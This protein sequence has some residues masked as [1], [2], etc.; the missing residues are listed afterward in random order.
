MITL[1][2]GFDFAVPICRVVF[3]LSS[4]SWTW[5][6]LRARN[7]ENF[8]LEI[9]QMPESR[10]NLHT[11]RLMSLFLGTVVESV[12]LFHVSERTYSSFCLALELAAWELTSPRQTRLVI[13]S[14][15]CIILY[16]RIPHP[17][18]RFLFFI[19]LFFLFFSIICD[20]LQTVIIKIDTFNIESLANFINLLQSLWIHL[21]IMYR[22]F[23]I[24]WKVN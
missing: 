5:I 1:Y 24:N 13:L 10:I 6:G 2:N 20:N 7:A 3:R 17:D 9:L 18:F 21:Q 8:I 14:L 15:L 12:G 23:Y 11:K 16:S 4:K 19:Y 22:S